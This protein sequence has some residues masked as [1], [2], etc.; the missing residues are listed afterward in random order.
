MSFQ[1]IK[2]DFIASNTIWSDISDTKFLSLVTEYVLEYNYDLI[3]GL[4]QEQSDQVIDMACLWHN[5]G[6]MPE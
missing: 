5:T 6:D 4:T 2:S 3:P 1:S